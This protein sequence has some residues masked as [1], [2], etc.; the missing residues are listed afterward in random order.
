MKTFVLI[1]SKKST[2]VGGSKYVN[3]KQRDKPVFFSGDSFK[4]YVLV[5]CFMFT[6]LCE[7]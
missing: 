6:L 1:T 2:S 7:R 5:L 3:L 4:I